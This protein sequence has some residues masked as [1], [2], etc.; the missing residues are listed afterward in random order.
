MVFAFALE[1]DKMPNM[2]AVIHKQFETTKMIHDT[3]IDDSTMI[4]K[5]K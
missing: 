3:T 5:R 2:S 1:Q 4:L